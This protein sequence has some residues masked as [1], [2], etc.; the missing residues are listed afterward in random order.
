MGFAAAQPILLAITN[1]T[2]CSLLCKLSEE[3]C[4]IVRILPRS[5]ELLWQLEYGAAIIGTTLVCCAVELPPCVHQQGGLRAV[6]VGA[7]RI[8]ALRAKAVQH[9][10]LPTG[11]GV[12]GQREYRACEASAA[13]ACRAVE[14]PRR[15]DD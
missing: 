6:T 5:K 4:D 1:V 9:R 14:V 3:T 2:F 13:P 8:R 12:G 10:F 15:V 11:L 7:V